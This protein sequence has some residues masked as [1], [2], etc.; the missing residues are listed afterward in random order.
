LGL[1]T[2][3]EE[4]NDGGRYVLDDAG[5]GVDAAKEGTVGPSDFSV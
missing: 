4:I 5:G 2:V 1:T 3:S